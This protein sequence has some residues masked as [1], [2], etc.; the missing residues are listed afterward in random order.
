MKKLKLKKRKEEPKAPSRITNE[1]VAEH[2]EQILAGGR[3]FKYPHQYARHKLVFNAIIIIL[4][5]LVLAGVIIWWQLYPAQNTSTFFYRVTRI[6]PVPVATV[7]GAQ[8][9]Y[10]DYLMSL[11]GSLHYLEQTERVNLD[12]EDGQRQVDFYKRLALDGAIAD[13]Y[14]AKLAREIGVTITD[15]QVDKV[16]DAGLNTVSGRISQDVYDDSTYS[17]FGYTADEYRHIIRRS[18]VRQEV[19]YRID[20]IA[21]KTKQAAESLIKAKKKITLSSLAKQ[22]DDK[23]HKVQLGASG[24]VPKTNFDGGLSQ[25]A[26]K[27]KEGQTSGFVRSTTGDGYY[28]VQLVELR[29]AQLSYNYLRIPLTKFDERLKTLETNDRIVEHISVKKSTGDV[30]RQ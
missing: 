14:A 7:D 4:V 28:L 1:T 19:S 8:V 18:L 5:T 16:I 27:L 3:R 9:R 12:S 6:L 23:G 30:I 25:I 26:L 11:G 22:L 13:T 2:R 15:E 21:T 24:L 20:D 17:T 29:D 10:S